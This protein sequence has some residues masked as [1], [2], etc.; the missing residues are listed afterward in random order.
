ME[1][2]TERLQGWPSTN[3]RAFHLVEANGSM[4]FKQQQILGPQFKPTK[5][6]IS[7]GLFSLIYSAFR[8]K[9]R[10]KETLHIEWCSCF[11]CFIG[12]FHDYDGFWFDFLHHPE[13][14]VGRRITAVADSIQGYNEKR[15]P[16]PRTY[17]TF[18]ITY[19]G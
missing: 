19:S 4:E 7:A 6:Y 15:V 2:N 8:T 3:G 11:Y 12:F 18:I 16:G 17:L 1:A 13:F 14:P 10:K 9:E 5:C